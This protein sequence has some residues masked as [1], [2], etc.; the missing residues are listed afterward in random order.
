MECAVK[1][2]KSRNFRESGRWEHCLTLVA[3]VVGGILWGNSGAVRLRHA[4]WR[5]Q[6]V[7]HQP[8]GQGSG[9]GRIGGAGHRWKA[10]ARNSRRAIAWSA[11]GGGLLPPVSLRGGS[12][13]RGAQEE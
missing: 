8:M 5:P 9:S 13:G 10:V 4:T 1:R 3:V 6:S 12:T 11:L 2:R 7:R